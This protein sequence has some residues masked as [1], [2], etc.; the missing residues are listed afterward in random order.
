[1][2]DSGERDPSIASVRQLLASLTAALV[3]EDYSQRELVIVRELADIGRRLPI[4]SSLLLRAALRLHFGQS[5]EVRQLTSLIAKACN[6]VPQHYHHLICPREAEVLIRADLKGEKALARYV[7]CDAGN[8]YD[9][10]LLLVRVILLERSEGFNFGPV[11]LNEIHE[12]AFET[13]S[14][15]ESP[16]VDIAEAFKRGSVSGNDLKGVASVVEEATA[17]W[18]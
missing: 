10:L 8:L 15:P 5:M 14:T 9:T 1:M 12:V 16:A 6:R 4:L 13:A 17:N 11:L 3:V 18:G 2:P 7:E